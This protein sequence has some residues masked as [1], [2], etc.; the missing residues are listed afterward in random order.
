[1]RNL[2]YKIRKKINAN[3][4]FF[5]K[6]KAM[7][8]GL[9]TPSSRLTTIIAQVPYNHGGSYAAEDGGHIG[10]GADGGKFVDFRLRGKGDAALA[11]GFR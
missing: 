10:D 4:W 2:G 5:L 11:H 8:L 6:K 9:R 3:G 1:M 7:D